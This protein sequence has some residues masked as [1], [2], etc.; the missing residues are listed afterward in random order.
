MK[1]EVIEALA[2]H[3]IS[4]GIATA[5]ISAPVIDWF[6]IASNITTLIAGCMGIA[7]AHFVIRNH[8]SSTA[9]NEYKLKRMKDEDKD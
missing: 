2:S 5:A 3:P 9:L 1:G 6:G 4:A 7:V 8:R